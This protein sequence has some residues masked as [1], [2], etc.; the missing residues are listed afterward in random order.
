[1]IKSNPYES[2]IILNRLSPNTGTCSVE[3]KNKV[4]HLH[5]YVNLTGGDLFGYK[6]YI[7]D[8]QIAVYARATSIIYLFNL[9]NP[10]KPIKYNCKKLIF[11]HNTI[12]DD[13]KK[14]FQFKKNTNKTDN[15]Y[16]NKTH[17]DIQFNP[18]NIDYIRILV[19]TYSLSSAVIISIISV[20]LQ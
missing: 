12:Y 10:S 2:A 16:I 1:M 3:F 8:D 13:D 9:Y 17:T 5:S 14:L 7:K 11:K 4:H 6:Y 18:K 15:K 19:F 20:L